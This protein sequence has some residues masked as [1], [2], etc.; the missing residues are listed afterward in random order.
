MLNQTYVQKFRIVL[1]KEMSTHRPSLQGIA[2]SLLNEVLSTKTT[3]LTPRKNRFHI[4]LF[5][6]LALIIVLDP[7]FKI[8]KGSSLIY[9]SSVV[10][11]DRNPSWSPMEI[12]TAS[13]Y[14]Y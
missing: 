1:C 11:N 9:K 14:L 6:L 5:H 7:F 12:S 13:L 3:F 10:K 8:F 4:Q 2:T